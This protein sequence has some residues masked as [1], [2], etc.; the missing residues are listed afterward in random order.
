MSHAHNKSTAV[1]TNR[2]TQTNVDHIEQRFVNEVERRFRNLRGLI[3]RTVG[4]KNDALRLGPNKSDRSTPFENADERERFDFPTRA[5]ITRAF[6]QWLRDAIQ[7]EILEPVGVD[8]IENG[9]H[10]TATYIRSA[11]INGV[12]QAVGLL[13][14]QGVGIENLPN[15]EIT[16]RPIHAKSLKDLFQRTYGNLESITED[17]VP[18]V[19]ETLTEGYAKG[20]NP[21]KMANRLTNE[22]RDIQ[23]VRAETLA[24]TETI[25]AHS[26]AMLD[27]YDRGGV[28]VVIHRWSAAD[29]DRTCAFCNRLDGN[30]LTTDEV[31]GDV[32]G[33]RGQV[34]RLQPPA[35]PNGRCVLMPQV[36]AD[37]PDTPFEERVPGG[38]VGG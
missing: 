32:V 37:P 6:L 25:N 10:W 28:D 3:R 16:Q 18:V 33:F 21:R 5:G 17:M 15:D 29:D 27:T 2:Q 26:T 22:I 24:R 1:H 12:N 31:R 30:L 35:H 8:D 7:E 23:H 13:L 38:V 9:K 36:G 11:Y 34:Y 20:W 19:R 4:Y 14:Q